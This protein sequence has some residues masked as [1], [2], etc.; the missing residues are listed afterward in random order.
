M[1]CN[2]SPSYHQLSFSV[3]N[4]NHILCLKWLIVYC[5]ILVCIPIVIFLCDQFYYN[6]PC[7]IL[8]PATHSVSSPYQILPWRSSSKTFWS[9][10][11]LCYSIWE[12]SSK[13]FRYNNKFQ[14]I[15][16]NYSIFSRFFWFP[17]FPD[18]LWSKNKMFV[19]KIFFDMICIKLCFILYIYVFPRFFSNYANLNISIYFS[20]ILI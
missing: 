7:L 13:P 10:C 14:T 19:I 15:L 2:L 12:L 4:T 5:C 18:Y 17:D 3:D 6:T 1:V 11:S 20:I 16:F 8:W 9:T